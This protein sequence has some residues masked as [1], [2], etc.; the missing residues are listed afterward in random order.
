MVAI[1]RMRVVMHT[2]KAVV[3]KMRA[4]NENNGGDE[5]PGLIMNHKQLQNQQRN[6][7]QEDKEGD[8]A[9]MVAA[10]TMGKGITADHY[11]QANHYR[12]EGDIMDD[13]YPK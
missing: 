9:M 5:K 1:V 10:E 8:Q 12:F 11:G 4:D 13:I 6:A 2:A 3:K 7:C